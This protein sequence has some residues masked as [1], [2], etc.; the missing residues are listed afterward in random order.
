MAK[1]KSKSQS[2]RKSAKNTTKKKKTAKKK[3]LKKAKKKPTKKKAKSTKA[4]ESRYKRK[5]SPKPKSGK[6]KSTKR[7][8]DAVARALDPKLRRLV[9]SIKSPKR[10]KLDAARAFISSDDSAESSTKLSPDQCYKRVLVRLPGQSVPDE[11]AKL[12]WTRI[13]QD[14]FTVNCPLSALEKLGASPGVEY[15]DAGVELTQA[16]DGSVPETKA[17]AVHSPTSGTAYTG[18]GVIVGII[19][20]GLDFTLDDFRNADGSTRIAFFWDQFLT[21]QG[22]ESHPTGFNHGVEYTAADIDG[23]L[24][25]ANPFNAIRHA[26]GPEEHGTHVAGTAAG[27]GR[28]GDAVFPAADYVGTAP[29]ATIIF[30][31][32]AAND[33]TSSFTDSAHVAE[34]VRYIFDRAAQLNM[35]CVINMSLGQNGGSHDG[36]SLVE[37]AIDSMLSVPGR[38]FVSAGGNEHNWR[39]HASRTLDQGATEIL[40]WKV[41]A[42]AIALPPGFPAGFGDFTPNELEIWYSSRDQ[43]RVRVIDPVG[44]QSAFVEQGETVNS[45]LSTGDT[46]FISSERFTV[47]NGDAQIYIEISPAPGTKLTPGTWQVEIEGTQVRD[48][49]FDAWIERDARRSGNR[50]RDQS[51]FLGADFSP[52]RTLGTPATSRRSIAVANY[53]HMTLAPSD[54]SGRGRTRD[55]RTKPEVAAPGTQIFSSNSM[56]GRPNPAHPGTNYPMRVSMSGTSM[57]APHVA[58]IV[59]LLLQADPDLTSEQIRKILIASANPTTSTP[60][61]D[62]AWGFGR[63]DARAAVDLIA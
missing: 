30:V 4:A 43:F 22:T 1:K 50:F 34:A 7:I 52:F 51:F 2:K 42:T 59:A 5:P 26:I 35:P 44:N 60:D 37:A 10:L 17:D 21:P 23:A 13:S 55:G 46:V 20:F 47:L 63:V 61:F 28:S 40:N 62:D 9:A 41:G 15:V 25:S 12:S 3:A 27:N 24:Q 57:A 48:G 29:D 14:V 56:G 32:P 38:T 11:L 53:N 16:L 36:E 8:M 33:Q 45:T 6:T 58:G 19:D 39:T 31:Q 54:S 49:G 18:Q